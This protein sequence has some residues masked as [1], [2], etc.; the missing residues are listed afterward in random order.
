ME[1]GQV[2]LRD[3]GLESEEPHIITFLW[4]QNRLQATYSYLDIPKVNNGQFQKLMVDTGS[5][6]Q[7]I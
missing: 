5:F 3:S 1:H 2:H 4:S 7:E 6:N